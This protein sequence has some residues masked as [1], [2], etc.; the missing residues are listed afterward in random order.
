ME[1]D[2][3]SNGDFYGVIINWE[4]RVQYLGWG[5]VGRITGSEPLV[6]HDNSRDFTLDVVVGLFTEHGIRKFEILP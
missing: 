5:R 3:L 1:N 2:T 4:D 6:N